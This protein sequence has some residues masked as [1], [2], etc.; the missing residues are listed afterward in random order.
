MA[1]IGGPPA[2]RFPP[3][4]ASACAH[5]AGVV[6]QRHAPHL[7]AQRVIPSIKAKQTLRDRGR[8]GKFAD[9]CQYQ[10]PRFTSIARLDLRGTAFL[11]PIKVLNIHLSLL[12]HPSEARRKSGYERGKL[13][14]LPIYTESWERAPSL[15]RINSLRSLSNRYLETILQKKKKRQKV[16]EK[17][18]KILNQIARSNRGPSDTPI[19]GKG[20]RQRE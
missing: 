19:R 13:D 4:H 1:V 14:F 9:S 11:S 6:T 18:G 8:G 16:E 3:F 5:R 10:A 2:V 15:K 20:A 12:I 7:S 17:R